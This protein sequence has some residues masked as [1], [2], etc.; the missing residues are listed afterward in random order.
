MYHEKLTGKLEGDSDDRGASEIQ[1]RQR[2]R[3]GRYQ[4]LSRR[5]VDGD[6]ICML[7]MARAEWT[8]VASSIPT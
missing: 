8:S 3:N 2:I 5:I 6:D 7:E 1:I 4:G